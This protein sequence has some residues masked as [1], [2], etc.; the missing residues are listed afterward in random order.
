MEVVRGGKVSCKTLETKFD[1]AKTNPGSPFP[2]SSICERD[3]L[4]SCRKLVIM[5]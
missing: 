1:S 2:L 3:C 5:K 4:T